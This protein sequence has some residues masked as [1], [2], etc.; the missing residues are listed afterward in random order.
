MQ[1]LKR[2]AA[3]DQRQSTHYVRFVFLDIPASGKASHAEKAHPGNNREQRYPL[4]LIK[5]V[6][7]DPSFVKQRLHS[8]GGLIEKAH[9]GDPCV[10]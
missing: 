6:E 7:P 10:S 2:F 9:G 4:L 1:E 3:P 5:S 8:F